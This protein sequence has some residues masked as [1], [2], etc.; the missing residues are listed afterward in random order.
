MKTRLRE[1]NKDST[2]TKQTNSVDTSVISSDSE[3]NRLMKLARQCDVTVKNLQ[4]QHEIALGRLKLECAAEIRQAQRQLREEIIILSDKNAVLNQQL[5]AAQEQLYIM[6]RKK[7]ALERASEES[8]QQLE[9][10][11]QQSKQQSDYQNQ[12]HEQEMAS[13]CQELF[14][15]TSELHTLQQQHVQVSDD[16]QEK[17]RQLDA[18]RR[19]LQQA[20]EQHAFEMRLLSEKL[21]SF[22][23]AQP[24]QNSPITVH[25]Q[26]EGSEILASDDED[27]S[28]PDS[29]QEQYETFVA[30]V[31]EQY[32]HEAQKL[33]ERYMAE[34]RA[35]V[36]EAVKKV[37]HQ[38]DM[39]NMRSEQ[40]QKLQMQLRNL[41]SASTQE[42]GQLRRRISELEEQLRK[43]QPDITNCCCR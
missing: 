36:E 7:V 15:A 25:F 4:A 17:T 38:C 6:S 13:V 5:R 18:C 41:E 28:D 43:P 42:I 12:K 24:L 1:I 11:V 34:K 21:S 31:K 20:Q 39:A 16:L 35:A 40:T 2:P 32:A 14:D 27:E 22:V 23:C 3:Q 26:D 10:A 37:E 29:M 19:D 9:K 30:T 8:A 33:K